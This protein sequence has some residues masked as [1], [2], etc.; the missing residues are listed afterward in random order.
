MFHHLM[1][2]IKNDDADCVKYLHQTKELQVKWLGMSESSSITSGFYEQFQFPFAL[3][4]LP[5][6]QL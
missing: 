4:Q 5:L 3:M 1:A 2:L 6:K